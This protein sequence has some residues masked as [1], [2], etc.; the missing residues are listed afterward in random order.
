MVE[1]KRLGQTVR[2][3]G[4]LQCYAC[5]ALSRPVLS[6]LPSEQPHYWR[7]TLHCPRCGARLAMHEPGHSIETT[8]A[9]LI[10]A[11]IL[12][13]PA[14]LMPVMSVYMLGRG[15]PDTI[16]SGVF[17]LLKSGQ[18]PL[19]LIVFVASIVVPILKLL[20]LSF[21]LITIQRRMQWRPK[22]RLRLYR[23]TEN[24]GRWSMVDVFVTA[25][26]SG[27]VQLGNVARI[28]ANV[29]SLSFAAVVV[30]TMLAARTL[31]THLIWEDSSTRKYH[32]E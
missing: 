12:Y 7:Q 3:A 28:E 31:D 1:N 24:I 18:W 29:G 13:I 5:G 14:N 25:I 17:S 19:A 32:H 21:L 20:A 26:L 11:M 22:D 4:L 2:S 27:L 9:L 23:V 10:S 6:N 8:W 30:L 16:L 15:H